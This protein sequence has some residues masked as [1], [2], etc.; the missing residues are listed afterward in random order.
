[1]LNESQSQAYQSL[2]ACSSHL[3]TEMA[4]RFHSFTSSLWIFKT[5]SKLVVKNHSGRVFTPWGKCKHNRRSV[6][7]FVLYFESQ[8]I[9]TSLHSKATRKEKTN[10][11]LLSLISGSRC[12]THSGRF[13]GG[14]W[15]D[16]ASRRL[17]LSLGSWTH[18]MEGEGWLPQDLFWP[19]H[20]RYGSALTWLPTN[21]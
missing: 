16:W 19:L 14:W 5:L 6:E 15:E 4:V 20:M 3:A 9:S 11:K 7:C 2:V 17:L 13:W 18:M 12:I 1:M 8:F 21:E 10:V